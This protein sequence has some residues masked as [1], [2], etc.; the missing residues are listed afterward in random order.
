MVGTGETEWNGKGM[1]MESMVTVI[2]GFA[3]RIDSKASQPMEPKE[4]TWEPLALEPWAE[5]HLENE[6]IY[7]QTMGKMFHCGKLHKNGSYTLPLVEWNVS[8]FIKFIRAKVSENRLGKRLRETVAKN[9]SDPVLVNYQRKKLISNRNETGKGSNPIKPRKSDITT[10]PRFRRLLGSQSHISAQNRDDN[11]AL[12]SLQD[13]YL[14]AAKLG[15][16]SYNRNY[17]WDKFLNSA[18]SYRTL[19]AGRYETM[20]KS[21][22]FFRRVLSSVG[23]RNRL[24]SN[25]AGSFNAADFY[26]IISTRLESILKLDKN[27]VWAKSIR[28]FRARLK[29]ENGNLVFVPWIKIHKATDIPVRTLS[30]CFSALIDFLESDDEIQGKLYSLYMSTRET[31]AAREIKQI[32]RETGLTVSEPTMVS[33]GYLAEFSPNECIGKPSLPWDSK[34]ITGSVIVPD[35]IRE[36]EDKSDILEMERVESETVTAKV[37]AQQNNDFRNVCFPSK[38][39]GEPSV[40]KEE[41]SKEWNGTMKPIKVYRPFTRMEPKPKSSL[42]GWGIRNILSKSHDIRDAKRLG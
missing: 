10:E 9:P 2:G 5:T 19:A 17:T 24:L 4:T 26:H 25:L 7:R 16:F 36:Q 1:T 18:F 27:S 31:Q 30:Y 22:I 28:I 14:I 42:T 12:D 37:K 38:A 23:Y 35:E 34:G 40:Q 13:A 20:K 29:L 15:Y 11:D 32:N 39:N 6:S 21:R 8:D 33:F 41:I 3:D